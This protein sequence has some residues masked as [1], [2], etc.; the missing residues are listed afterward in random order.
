MTVDLVTMESHGAARNE[1]RDLFRL[2]WPGGNE[3]LL[4]EAWEDVERL[5]RGEWPG[6]YPCDTPYHNLTHVVTVTLAMA[7][8]LHGAALDGHRVTADEGLLC[9][10]AALFHDAGLIRGVDDPETTG[11]ELTR[12]HVPRGME[13]LGGYLVGHG[14]DRASCGFA[15]SLLACTELEA[16]ICSIRFDSGERRYMGAMLKAADL[17]GQMADRRYAEKILLL[18]QELREADKE[19]FFGE[20]DLV[21]NTPAFCRK[22]LGEMVDDDG[23]GVLDHFRTHFR[24]YRGMDRN[25]YTDQISEQI[26]LLEEVVARGGDAYRAHLRS[27]VVKMGCPPRNFD[28]IYPK[29]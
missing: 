15:R 20:R 19:A 6:Y 18:A 13:M 26:S 28:A 27:G 10:V 9:L 12:R 8:L 23:K 17:G 1:V 29:Q 24:A 7:R 16:D 21:M 4:D 5:Y 3:A 11:A 25:V 2:M 14:W 22:A